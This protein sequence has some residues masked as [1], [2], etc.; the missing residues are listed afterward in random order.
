MPL[1]FNINVNSVYRIVQKTVLK[2]TQKQP[3]EVFY[4][5]KVFL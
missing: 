2:L 5:K 1:N 4:E 3:T